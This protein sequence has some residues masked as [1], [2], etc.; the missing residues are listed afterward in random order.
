M[1]REFWISLIFQNPTPPSDVGLHNSDHA[2]H[3]LFYF[4]S[5]EPDK[6]VLM[7]W[8]ILLMTAFGACTTESKCI[9][10]LATTCRNRNI[11]APFD[12]SLCCQPLS[13][14]LILFRSFSK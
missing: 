13:L 3:F 2:I 6:K 4:P 11:L 10:M 12:R 1:N 9:G 8:L 7:S 14:S 5:E